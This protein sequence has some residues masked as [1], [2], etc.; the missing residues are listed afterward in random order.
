[1]YVLFLEFLTF[2]HFI[3]VS[4]FYFLVIKNIV[5]NPTGKPQSRLCAAQGFNRKK[6][7]YS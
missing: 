4:L 3:F 6:I 2:S 5:V 7:S 1:M